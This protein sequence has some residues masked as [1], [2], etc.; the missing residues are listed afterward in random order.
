MFSAAFFHAD[1]RA[2]GVPSDESSEPIGNVVVACSPLLGDGIITVGDGEAVVWNARL[3][4][5]ARFEV[6]Q[7]DDGVVALS[8]DLVATAARW[9]GVRLWSLDQG[10]AVGEP[11]EAHEGG[12]LD[13]AR[14]GD[15][16]VSVGD[17]GWLRLWDV[18]PWRLAAEFRPE[19]DGDVA[20]VAGVG[21]LIAT[22]GGESVVRLW[23]REGGPAGSIA[24]DGL[25]EA[26]S[27]LPD[28][29]LGVGFIDG[30]VVV[31]PAP[32]WRR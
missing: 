13:L 7:W 22:A 20:L 4:E 24:V 11:F 26:L 29:H 23:T 9:G 8:S 15:Q 3:E 18:Q 19:P 30:L 32:R 5:A 28:S 1:A 14:L 21:D 27:T 6:G 10:C 16:L 2:D 12:V 31:R 17:D 25:P